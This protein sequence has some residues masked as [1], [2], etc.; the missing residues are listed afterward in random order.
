M[1]KGKYIQKKSSNSNACMQKALFKVKDVQKT[2]PKRNFNAKEG[3]GRRK[4][5]QKRILQRKI[6]EKKTSMK[7]KCL[8][9]K[10]SMAA[11]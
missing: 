5:M 7:E 4:Y 9:Q 10:H 6:S 11:R 1:D 8:Q 3:R 2:L